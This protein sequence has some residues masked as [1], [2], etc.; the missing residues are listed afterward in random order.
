MYTILPE[1]DGLFRAETS[2]TV[3]ILS[4]LSVSNGATARGGPRL[5]SKVSSILR[6]L[7]RLFIYFKLRNLNISQLL[8]EFCWNCI[9]NI[10]FRAPNMYNTGST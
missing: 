8:S 10:I 5:P 2:R 6:V 7:E 9:N 3:Y 1:E 4:S